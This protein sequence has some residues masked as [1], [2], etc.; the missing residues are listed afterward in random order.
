MSVLFLKNVKSYSSENPIRIDLTK[1]I[2]IFYG[3]NG[4]GKSTISGY[5]YS[6][7]SPAYKYSS[8]TSKDRYDYFVYNN[9]FIEDTFYN[10]AEQPGIFTISKNNKNALTFIDKHEIEIKKI[11][12]TI[13]NI[14]KVLAEKDSMINTISEDF[15]NKIW[16]KTNTLRNTTLKGLLIG[17]LQKQS[18]LREFENRQ[19]EEDIKSEDLLVEYNKLVS[20]KGKNIQTISIPLYINITETDLELLETALISSSD[21][22]LS[23]LIKELNNSDWVR[24]GITYIKNNQ[25]PFCQN[26]TISTEFQDEIKKVFDIT[27]ENK[28]NEINN[29]YTK[30]KKSNEIYISQLKSNIKLCEYVSENDN[31][32]KVIEKLENNLNINVREVGNKILKPSMTIKLIDLTII[33]N[34]IQEIIEAY[35]LEIKSINEKVNE[36]Q[37]NIDNLKTKLWKTIRFSCQDIVS[38]K[39]SQLIEINSQKLTLERKKEKYLLDKKRLSFEINEKKKSLSNMDETIDKINQTLISLGIN[40][41]GIAKHQKIKNHFQIFRK[42][43]DSNNVYQS[44]SEG[45]K[46]IITFLYFL[47]LCN[48]STQENNSTMANKIIVI[49]DPIS[50]LSHQYIY[51]IASLIHHKLIKNIV[52][53]K[54]LI[55]TH[56]LFFFQEMLKIAPQRNKEFNKNY[57]LYRVIKNE[58]SFIEKLERNEIKNDYQALWL[59]LKDIRNGNVAPVV[60]PNIMRN[61]LEYF[62]S[63]LC[64]EDKL[65]ESLSALANS[66]VCIE[67][68]AFYRYMNSGSHH[69]GINISGEN[70]I[71]VSKYFDLFEKIFKQTGNL[72]HYKTMIQNELVT[73]DEEN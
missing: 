53:N 48:G 56:N 73:E 26:E 67:Y 31:L 32:W 18:F 27:Y 59:I 34:E 72:N 45:E 10:K 60:A 65:T 43:N 12:E 2:N 4:S 63:F 19:E 42:D 25:C 1:K 3:Q 22:Y 9:L 51:E 49:D 17:C 5:F 57:N 69:A 50:S 44:L 40:Q 6:P 8:F 64:T 21:S 37:K 30:Y 13:E 68:K 70:S 15:K 71:S 33:V 20:Y 36:Y 46:T 66:E 47:E 52:D 35:N 54:I 11:N 38:N 58:F 23:I 24:E 28:I 61:I 14:D 62:F 16:N 55:L 41:F 7:N 29:F 39:N